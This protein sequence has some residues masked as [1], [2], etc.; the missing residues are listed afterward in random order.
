M[1]EKIQPAP[2]CDPSQ[3]L[4]PETERIKCPC[5]CFHLL[6][7]SRWYTQ[8]KITFLCLIYPHKLK[9]ILFIDHLYSYSDQTA[10]SLPLPGP[11][12]WHTSLPD[13]LV[14]VQSP[15]CNN[16]PFGHGGLTH[17]TQLPR[18]CI[19]Y[20]WTGD[21]TT[22]TMDTFQPWCPLQHCMFLPFDMHV[23]GHGPW[24]V[25]HVYALCLFFC[26]HLILWIS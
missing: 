17:I 4:C 19:S 22:G 14:H 16:P 10:L 7:T 18:R 24:P 9:L 21:E 11:G 15:D 2:Q 20:H 26:M 5:S 1:S 13:S 25:D 12:S 3:A 6:P 8:D 23:A